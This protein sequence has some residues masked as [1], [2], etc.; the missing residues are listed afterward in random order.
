MEDL[1]R[2]RRTAAH[3]ARKFEPDTEVLDALDAE[4]M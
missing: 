4:I 3:F 1:P 2:L